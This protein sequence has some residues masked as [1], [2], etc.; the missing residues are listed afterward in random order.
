MVHLRVL[1]GLVCRAFSNLSIFRWWTT[2]GL[3][4]RP[5]KS[6]ELSIT[7]FDFEHLSHA[8][9]LHFSVDNDTTLHHNRRDEVEWLARGGKNQSAP[10]IIPPDIFVKIL[11]D[12]DEQFEYHEPQ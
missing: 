3:N 5:R 8:E 2:S 9:L 10:I 6:A 7:V 1:G 12:S 4:L 11:D